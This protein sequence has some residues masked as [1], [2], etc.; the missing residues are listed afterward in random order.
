MAAEK[1][2]VKSLMV[3]GECGADKNNHPERVF[4]WDSSGGDTGFICEMCS[5][6]VLQYARQSELARSPI[7]RKMVELGLDNLTNHSIMPCEYRDGEMFDCGLWEE[8]N[9]FAV[10]KNAQTIADFFDPY[11]ALEFCKSEENKS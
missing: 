1:F 8:G 3:C 6:E 2:A 10:I 7:L 5:N 11:T 4:A 9:I